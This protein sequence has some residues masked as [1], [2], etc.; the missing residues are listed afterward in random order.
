MGSKT[1]LGPLGA[2]IKEELFC[3]LGAALGAA[4]AAVPCQEFE[5]S[6]LTFDVWSVRFYFQ[7]LPEM[8]SD[9]HFKTIQNR[10]S[11]GFLP[12]IQH[13][14]ALSKELRSRNHLFRH[15]LGLACCSTLSTEVPKI[16]RLQSMSWRLAS[17]ISWLVKDFLLS[18]VGDAT[19]CQTTSTAKQ[20]IWHKH[21]ATSIADL[22]QH[23]GSQESSA[24][25]AT[26]HHD[27]TSTAEVSCGASRYQ[28]W[29]SLIPA[30]WDQKQSCFKPSVSNKRCSNVLV[31]CLV[32]GWCLFCLQIC[33]MNLPLSRW[34]E[35]REH[36]SLHL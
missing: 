12:R 3:T 11:S 27:C 17:R 19:M 15:E 5:E 25:H 26:A 20:R 24:W 21:A 7:E 14:D 33:Q 28:F 1:P 36:H 23:C 31:T 22:D 9:S 30:P 6:M 34:Q 16:L 13:W 18:K 8:L 29:S 10:N 32:V 35:E 4:A 2:S